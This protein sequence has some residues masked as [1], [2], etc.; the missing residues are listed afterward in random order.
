MTSKLK[1]P[2]KLI[3]VALP[4][5]AINLAAKEEKAVPRRG[6]PQTLHYWWA[7]R[8]LAATRA[9]IF[10]QMVNDPGYE[11]QLGRG[12]SKDKAHK[13]RER[14]FGILRRLVRW[15]NTNNEEVLREAR[16]E[17]LKSWQETC[18]LNKDHPQAKELFDPSKLPVFHDPFGGG[19]AIPIEALRLGLSSHSSDLNPVAVII[20]KAMIEIPYRF[21]NLKPVG[22][23]QARGTEPKLIEGWHG[24]MG[25]AEDVRRYGAWVQDEALKRV[26][27]QYPSIVVTAEDAKGR[28]DLKALV[29][30]NLTVVAWLWARTVRSPN[31]AFSDSYVPLASTF[32]LSNRGGKEA[33]VDPKVEGNSFRFVVKVGVAPKGAIN[34]TKKAGSNFQCLFSGSPITPQFL[35]SEAKSGKMG[36]RLMAIVAESPQGRIYLSPNE[37]HEAVA[38]R[39]N[40]KWKPRLL[41]PTP[42]HEVD[43]LPMYGMPTWGDVFTN[44]QLVI[45]NTFSDLIGEAME[46]CRN[47]A[48]AKGMLDDKKG[49]EGN[50]T[51]ATAYGQAIGVYLACALSR[52]ASYNNS[53]CFWNMKGGSVAQIFARQAIPMSWDFIEVNPLTKMSGNWIGGID[54]VS[55]VIDKLPTISAGKVFQHDAKT[56]ASFIQS[57]AIISTDPP[58]YDNIAYAELSDFFYVWLQRS[59]GNVWPS[60]LDKNTTPKIEELVAAPH[61]H[62][63]KSEAE[64]FFLAGMTEAMKR[65]LEATHPAFPVTIYYA[66][67]QSQTEG[68]KGTTSTGWETFLAALLDAGFSVCGTWPLRTE[69]DSGVKTGKNVLASSVLLVCRPRESNAATCSRRDFM[70]ELNSK[71]PEALEEMTAGG[72]HSPVA[73]VDLSQAIIGPGMAIFSKYSAVLEADGKP[74]SVKT[75]LQLINRFFAE[76]DF[77]HDTQFCLSWFDGHGWE[78]GKFGEADVLARA[79]GTSVEGLKDSGLVESAAGNLKLLR[80]DELSI[81]WKSEN[82]NRVSIWGLL[83][84]MVRLLNSHG[85]TGAGEILSKVNEHSENIRTL[86]YRLYTICER[87]GWAQEAGRYNELITA[88]DAIE[89]AAQEVG[90]SGVQSSFFGEEPTKSRPNSKIKKSVR[91]KK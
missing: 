68:G 9:V 51:G 87:K 33:Y 82:D 88:W 21:S 37:Q 57:P 46:K 8:P 90:Y 89:N 48:L 60:M 63:G 44:R 62:G 61:R 1:I 10:S 39:A 77:D 66:F 32:V 25:L 71:L 74:M 13:E 52:L 17:I 41:V 16:E 28:P 83:H 7:R 42:C 85:E 49:I 81:K 73:P 78:S 64:Q 18:A 75:A 76:D 54:W 72:E 55:D 22:E 11:R 50:G 2:K 19:G 43:R 84:H 4:L 80:P 70:R 27:E 40:P 69:R 31:P 45:L 65:A 34:G 5:D 12:L 30:Q 29:G 24:Y 38:V 6:H 35:R 15:E 26:G 91:K 3:E 86:G 20:N 36:M 67:K 14:L 59:V 53:I 47:D 79:K 56:V 58:Y 23:N